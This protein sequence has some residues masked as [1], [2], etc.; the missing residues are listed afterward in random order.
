MAPCR[1]VGGALRAHN[2]C[3]CGLR[4]PARRPWTSAPLPAGLG[5][6]LAGQSCHGA[7]LPPGSIRPALLL[8]SLVVSFR[9]VPAWGVAR[10][11]VSAGRRPRRPCSGI[12][13]GIERFD[14]IAAR[15][16]VL[17]AEQAPWA[18][19]R[20][21]AMAAD[22]EPGRVVPAVG[23]ELDGVRQQAG[24]GY[25]AP[26]GSVVAGAGPVGPAATLASAAAGWMNRPARPSLPGRLTR[27]GSWLLGWREGGSPGPGGLASR[28]NVR[29]TRRMRFTVT[30]LWGGAAASRRG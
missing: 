14:V 26:P 5:T 16:Q 7:L 8:P 3:F 1:L 22:P 29:R 10:P 18:A 25:R 17:A 19:H 4:S 20:L 13:L 23:A 2:G 30:S 24:Y 12:G 27:L 9:T 28:A 6:V 15:I 11:P 21:A